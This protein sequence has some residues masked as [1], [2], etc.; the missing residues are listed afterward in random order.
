MILLGSFS[1]PH[2]QLGRLGNQ[3][4][5]DVLGTGDIEVSYSWSLT[6]RISQFSEGVELQKNHYMLVIFKQIL[7]EKLMTMANL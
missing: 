3:S 5:I 6:S 2:S 1:R 4:F 7:C